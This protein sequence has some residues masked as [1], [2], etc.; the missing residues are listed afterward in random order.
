MAGGPHWTG[1]V[2]SLGITIVAVFGAYIAWNLWKTNENVLREK[3]FDRRYELT[4][5]TQALI[6]KIVAD[7]SI[8][9]RDANRFTEISH[10][11]RFLFSGD[12]A[13]YFDLMRRKAA[14]LATLTAAVDGK[15]A[16]QVVDE[17]A[18]QGALCDWFDTQVE[19][20]FS[21]MDKYMRFER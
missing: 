14:E 13:Q 9:W 17:V 20:V 4:Q 6:A 18:A 3:M 11:A 19:E 2:S 8:S 7:G 16:S 21:R 15:R 1:V 10:R 5:T 12:D